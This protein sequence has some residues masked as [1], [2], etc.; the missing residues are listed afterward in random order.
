MV[1][2]T[3][4]SAQIPHLWQYLQMQGMYLSRERFISCFQGMGKGG[5]ECLTYTGGFLSN[6]NPRQSICHCKIFWGGLPWVPTVA[7]HLLRKI[8][9][10]IFFGTPG[11]V[12]H[13]APLFMGFSWQEYRSGLPWATQGHLPDT[14]DQIQV[15]CVS[16]TEGWFFTAE[17]PGKPGM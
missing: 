12:A 7:W 17:P 13:Q 16:C 5:S 14:R 6:F 1:C 9:R 10:V 2:Y 11:A 15:S 8:K 3:N 4:F